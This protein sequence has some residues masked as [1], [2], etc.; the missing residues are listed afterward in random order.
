MM[1]SRRTVGRVTMMRWVA[2][3][4]VLAWVGLPLAVSAQVATRPPQGGSSGTAQGR[5]PMLSTPP[6][7]AF[8]AERNYSIPNPPPSSRSLYVTNLDAP[9]I[10]SYADGQS[11]QDRTHPP[12]SLQNAVILFFGAPAQQGS[13]PGVIK[14][15]TSGASAVFLNLSQVEAAVDS[16]A[17]Q[18]ISSGAGSERLHIIVGTSNDTGLSGTALYNVGIAWANLINRINVYFVSQN[19]YQVVAQAGDDIEMDYNDPTTSDVWLQGFDSVRTGVPVYDSG[20]ITC[21]YTDNGNT[22]Q[23]CYTLNQQVW[24]QDN[25]YHFTWG[26]ASSRAF[27][28]VYN[29]TIANEWYHL[30]LY[31]ANSKGAQMQFDG[32]FS[33]GGACQQNPDDTCISAYTNPDDAWNRITQYLSQGNPVSGGIPTLS[34]IPWSSDIEDDV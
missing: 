2:F 34:A 1:W 7:S 25:I 31:A 21:P 26:N 8:V 10:S 23:P 15:K 29:Q 13:T 32:I 3:V 17:R 16:Y 18:Y 30:S 5:P 11:L 33:E 24:T 27:V 9:K 20:N 19:W 6:S 12:G 28:Q 22:N 4:S 14:V